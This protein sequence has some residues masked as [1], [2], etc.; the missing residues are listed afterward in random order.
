MCPRFEDLWAKAAD[1]GASCPVG[2]SAHP[3]ASD[4]ETDDLMNAWFQERAQRIEGSLLLQQARRLIVSLM[5]DGDLGPA[6]RR[7]ALRLVRAIREL[8]KNTG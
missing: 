8:E 2:V 1:D 6:D 3:P 7:R 5:A 4:H